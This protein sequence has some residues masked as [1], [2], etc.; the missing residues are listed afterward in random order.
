MAKA[1]PMVNAGA[2]TVGGDR[3]RRDF[4][5]R[6]LPTV[7]PDPDTNQDIARLVGGAPVRTD[8]TTAPLPH[9]PAATPVPPKASRAQPRFY[10]IDEDIARIKAEIANFRRYTGEDASP[11]RVIRAALKAFGDE[12][13]GQDR[14]K[15]MGLIPDGRRR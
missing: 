14:A 11:S 4:S 6:P 3:L 8:D 1:P 5:S 7:D 10:L 12:L 15:R 9:T 13:S 2:I